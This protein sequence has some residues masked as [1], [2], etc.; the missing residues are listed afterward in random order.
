MRV[1]NSVQAVCFDIGGVLVEVSDGF[2]AEELTELLG[3]PADVVRQMLILNGKTRPSTPETLAAVMTEECGLPGTYDGVLAAIR[4]RFAAIEA[5]ILYPDA[6]PVLRALREQGWRVVF[7]SNAVG[8]TGLHRPAYYDFAETVLHSWEIGACKPDPR[9]FHTVEERTGLAPGEL[10]NVGDS[11]NADIRGALDV[12]WSAIHLPRTGG[13]A[14]P[15][16]LVPV[17]A[18]LHQ[19]LSLLPERSGGRT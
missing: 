13:A 6:L 11:F 14:T 1:P 3:A 9:A 18:D 10:V 5:P 4:R 7:L 2:L 15:S 17:C 16:G 19:V 8:H 12:G